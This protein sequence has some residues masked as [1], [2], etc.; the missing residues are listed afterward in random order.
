MGSDGTHLQPLHPSPKQGVPTC[1]IPSSPCLGDQL[2]PAAHPPQPRGVLVPSSSG[3]RGSETEGPSPWA[4]HPVGMPQCPFAGEDVQD[5]TQGDRDP[6]QCCRGSCSC[7][8]K[9]LLPVPGMLW[10]LLCMSRV[11]IPSLCPDLLV[12]VA[13]TARRD[14]KTHSAE[15]AEELSRCRAD[16]QTPD[17]REPWKTL[18]MIQPYGGGTAAPRAPAGGIHSS[19]M[20]AAHRW[21]S[22]IQVGGREL[23]RFA[24]CSHH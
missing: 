7:H 20:P 13:T 18:G 11:S 9:G 4:Q 6:R 14:S 8:S 23:E 5:G 19:Q 3:C 10:A 16:P 22:W 21:D 1:H 15:G 24:L 17:H 2:P 12:C